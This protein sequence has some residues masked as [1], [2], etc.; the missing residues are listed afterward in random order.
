VIDGALA[1]PGLSRAAEDDPD[2]QERPGAIL[3]FRT[4]CSFYREEQPRGVVAWDTR[5][6]T[7]PTRVPAIK[8][9]DF[10]DA[11]SSSSRFCRN[12]RGVGFPT[13]GCWI[14]G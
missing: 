6:R 13:Q 4:S 1:A 11:M 2:A 5:R 8:G 3:G 7:Y 14:R 10:D 9:P 12:R